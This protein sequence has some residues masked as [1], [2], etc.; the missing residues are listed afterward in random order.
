MAE[1][2]LDELFSGDWREEEDVA[3]S[4]Q[5]A[6]FSEEVEDGREA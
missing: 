6:E 3:G 5:D 2:D 1:G 4:K